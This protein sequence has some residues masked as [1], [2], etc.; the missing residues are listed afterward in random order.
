MLGFPLVGTEDD[1]T[2]YANT[3]WPRRLS[4]PLFFRNALGYLGGAAR[5]AE[6]LSVRPGEVL[7]FPV[8]IVGDRRRVR[9]PSGKLLPLKQT[10]D[11]S[12]AFVAT[13]ELGLYTIERSEADVRVA[14]GPAAGHRP[15][16]VSRSRASTVAGSK[17]SLLFITSKNCRVSG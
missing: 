4:F 3:D 5:T 2:R 14:H 11:A 15:S 9:S 6:L 12:Y 7:T 13:D 16:S 10:G 17:C 8:E 1:G